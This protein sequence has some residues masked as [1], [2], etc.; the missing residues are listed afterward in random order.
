MSILHFFEFVGFVVIGSHILAKVIVRDIWCRNGILHIIDDLLHIPT[1]NIM[2]EMARYN[3]LRFVQIYTT[4]R[5][6]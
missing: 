4:L 6:L 1:R 2:E 5:T 3:D